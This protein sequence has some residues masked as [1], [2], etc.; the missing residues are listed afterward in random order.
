MTAQLKISY[1]FT[2]K[3]EP[4]GTTSNKMISR[5]LII[6]LIPISLFSQEIKVNDNYD[7][8]KGF[9]V[10]RKG[11]T[12]FGSVK[13][14]P[15][16][17]SCNIVFFNNQE[18]K[19]VEYTPKD[20][21]AYTRGTIIYKAVDNYRFMQVISRGKINLYAYDFIGVQTNFYDKILEKVNNGPGAHF[22]ETFK[23]FIEKKGFQLQSVDSAN[24]KKFIEPYITDDFEV[25]AKFKDGIYT[26][27]HSIE[28]LINEYNKNFNF[29]NS[30]RYFHKDK[31]AANKQNY[32]FKSSIQI[33]TENE[34]YIYQLRNRDNE[35]VDQQSFKNK[36]E[37][38]LYEFKYTGSNKLELNNVYLKNIPQEIFTYKNLTYLNLSGTGIY[39]LPSDISKLDELETL[40]LSDNR[41]RVIPENIYKLQKLLFLNL[42]NNK[43]EKLPVG[44]WGLTSLQ[45]LH[46]AYNQLTEI[47]KE[48]GN[49]KELNTLE[50]FGNP[51]RTV[52]K[53]IRKLKKLKHSDIQWLRK[54][55]KKSTKIVRKLKVKDIK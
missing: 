24:Y 18:N 28:N 9:V 31:T 43:I 33:D 53:E 48:I 4:G 37:I 26:H 21:S 39:A 15:P 55:N 42:N 16:I 17:E 1:L 19:V 44:F 50:I 30:Y 34:M 41:I 5:I 46:I 8:S 20:V 35:V 36:W 54:L 7:F 51:I 13:N 2:N 6:L 49:L 29:Y 45:E 23:Y 38:L 12:L 10:L 47:P 11:D 52:H 25:L 27:Y 40:I 22:E 32:Q 14:I 3:K